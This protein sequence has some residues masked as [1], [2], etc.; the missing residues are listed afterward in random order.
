MLRYSFVVLTASFALT[1]TLSAQTKQQG[2]K[3]D[4]ELPAQVELAP[5]EAAK[6]FTGETPVAFTLT[7]NFDRLRHDRKEDAPWRWA[8]LTVADSAEGNI[9]LPL[10]VRTRGIWRLNQCD[11]PPL[12][13]DFVKSTVKQT[14]FAKLDKPKLVMHCRDNDEYEQYIL[15]EF[16]LY[17]IY[18]L[19]TQ[20]SNRVRL[21]RVTY[22][23]SGSG[24]VIARRWAFLEE[25]PA[26]VAY[27][28]GGVLVKQKGAG[29]S[30]LEPN[31]DAL[32][33][34]F[35]YF[36]G[37]TDWSVNG[38]HNVEVIDTQLG[39]VP[40]AYDFDFSGAVNT[41]YATVDPRLP[42][43]RVR[44]RLYRGYC[45]PLE[46]YPPA[47]AL[48]NAKRDSIYALYRDS[49]G[50]LIKGDRVKETLEYFDDFY[51]TINDPR[52]AKHEIEDR[53]LGGGR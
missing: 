13:L 23:D 3:K 15:Q 42:I 50:Q 48:F 8:S 1:A 12:R 18:N 21:A 19:L 17:R 31:A 28:V 7:A 51:K 52:V 26:A 39:Y 29:P 2:K 16:Q 46:S 41:R 49:L 5:H 35:Q 38:L 32:F 4:K 6:I 43:H 22:A 53:C 37:N 14:E 36:I 34:L 24:K 33:A 25:E 20:Y 40:V 11:L 27:R 45:V 9:E 30:D 47:Y 10:K 44:D